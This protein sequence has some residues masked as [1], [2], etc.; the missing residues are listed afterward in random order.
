LLLG[1]LSRRS[2]GQKAPVS[3]QKKEEKMSTIAENK[4]DKNPP[5]IR[6]ADFARHGKLKLKPHPGFP[7]ARDRNLAAVNV[8]ELGTSCGNFPLVIARYPENQR[9][10]LM[11]MLGLKA[12]ENVYF[13]EEFWESTYVPLA[14]QRH[15]FIVGIDERVTGTIQ[16]ATCLEVDSKCL[17][18]TDGLPLFNADGTQSDVLRNADQMLHS[19]FDAGAVTEKFIAKLQE[20]NLITPLVIVLQSQQGE[21]NRITGLSTVDE[22]RLKALSGDQLKEL[23]NLDFLAPCYLMLVSL[24]QLR[25][26]IR[27]R[28]RRGGEQITNFKLEFPSEP[29]PSANA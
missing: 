20:L 25:Q 18:E 21:L 24:Y 12:G 4:V 26:L 15:P 27:L 17:G 23:Q 28:N 13:G 3:G 10:V 7:H 2:I 19:M 5:N 22:N 1:S 11:A 29:Q 14:I 6:T 9:M 8:S 16:L